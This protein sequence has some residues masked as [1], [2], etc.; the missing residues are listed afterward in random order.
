MSR[1]AVPSRI[2]SGPPVDPDRLKA[3]IVSAPSTLEEGFR[4][5]DVDLAAGRAGTID[6][7]GLD[8]SGALTLLAVSSGDLDL[9]MLRLLDQQIWI[10]DQRDLLRRIHEQ[11]ALDMERPVRALLLSPTFT[12]RFLRRLELLKQPVTA[13]LARPVPAAGKNVL[14]I[15]DAAP[16][17]GLAAAESFAVTERPAE[18]RRERPR[19][20]EPRA[21]R[22]VAVPVTAE[23]VVDQDGD[24]EALPDPFPEETDPSDPFETLS[25]Q[26]LDEFD[27]FERERRLRRR[28]PA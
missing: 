16:I 21:D 4:V 2:P 1:R 15:E 14:L 22:E 11:A 24:A 12:E 5:L 13:L 6:I 19:A 8:R 10:A 26:E 20:F 7:L 27:R 28:S 25:T 9:A 18:E 17:F 23:L 3:L